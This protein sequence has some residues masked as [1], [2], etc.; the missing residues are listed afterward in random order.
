MQ[1]KISFVTN[2]LHTGNIMAQK[3][4]MFTPRKGQS[5]LSKID[6]V[7][8][9]LINE[10][11]KFSISDKGD[12]LMSNTLLKNALKT[13]KANNVAEND[14]NY[15][16]VNIGQACQ[17]KLGDH[18]WLELVQRLVDI[19]NLLKI[20][21][22]F[23]FSSFTTVYAVKHSWNKHLI[24]VDGFHHLLA[25]YVNIRAGNIKGWDPEN[26]REFPVPTM[27]WTTDDES[28]PLRIALE[29]NGGAQLEWGEIEH[30]RCKSAIARLFPKYAKAED[31]LALEQVSACLNEGH[32]VPLV[33]KHKDTKVKEAITHIGAIAS[34]KNIDRLKY[35]LGENY[36]HWPQDKRSSGM[37]GF[38]GNIFDHLPNITK[39]QMN[40]YHYI[41]DSVFGSLE[42]AKSATVKAMTK[43]EALTNDN[44]KPSG[45]DN[46][47]LAVVEIIYQD[48]LDG[49]GMIT[50]SRGSYVYVNRL[51][52][53]TNIV[54]ALRQ[55]PNTDFA[56]QIDSL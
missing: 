37:F 42:G 19:T 40:D 12:E 23:R 34:N 9:K 16:P 33:K 27:V 44:W 5:T 29:I 21:Q 43:M 25:L 14:P 52:N 41:I 56:Q 45:Q 28:F 17:T 6:N 1:E 18:H 10:F 13:N 3:K 22:H 49:K 7:F 47:L 50:G 32:S 15:D 4:R 20:A 24:T 38:Y 55:L 48:Y 46:A 36:T 8:I 54:D 30:L 31:K 53:Q 35:I 26:W 11:K 39:A 2:N 51:G